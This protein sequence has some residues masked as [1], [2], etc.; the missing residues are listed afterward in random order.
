MDAVLFV[1]GRQK[2]DGSGKLVGGGHD[3]ASRHAKDEDIR[4]GISEHQ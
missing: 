4:V 2:G 1:S 3:P